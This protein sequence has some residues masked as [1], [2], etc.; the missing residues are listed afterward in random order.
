MQNN[1]R[2]STTSLLLTAMILA[3]AGMGFSAFRPGL[4][5]GSGSGSGSSSPASVAPAEAAAA[6]VEETSIRFA[7]NLTIENPAESPG[8]TEITINEPWPGGSPIR[9]AVLQ[10]GAQLRRNRSDYA[11]VV[12]AEP[13]R[14]ISL[15]TPSIAHMADLGLLG[16]LVG[17]ENPDYIYNREVLSQLNSGDVVRVGGGPELDME[18]I[19]ALQPDLVFVS[20]LGPDEAALRR[21]SSASIPVIVLSDWR[22]QSPLGRAE[23]LKLFGAVFNRSAAAAELFAERAERYE[24]LQSLTTLLPDKDRPRI[25]ANGPWQGSWPVPA[26]DSYIA[27]LFADAGGRYLWDDIPGAG[28]HFLDLE[29]ILA[30]AADAE[31]W[32]NLNHD[33]NSRADVVRA[34][35]RLTRFG[36]YQTG[37]MYH[38]NARVRNSS[39]NDFWESGAGRPDLVLADL[40]HIMHPDLLPDH[41]PVYYQ[42]LEP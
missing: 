1:S 12:G 36:A 2:L 18:R 6:T 33:W 16:R 38:H 14:V 42:K 17:V 11:A 27:R 13:Q 37:R 4:G 26:A 3:A 19:V 25:M 22:E 10:P 7:E 40:V 23:W 20:A 41:S 39:A 32:F 29:S 31:Y 5:S 21:L 34:D 9:Y 28:S 35:A 30:R 24:Q 8:V 15:V